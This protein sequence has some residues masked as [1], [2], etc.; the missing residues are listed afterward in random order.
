MLKT[1]KLPDRTLNLI[2]KLS[3]FVGKYNKT[4]INVEDE[5][6]E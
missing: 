6:T 2:N 4:T 5:I 1:D 3:L